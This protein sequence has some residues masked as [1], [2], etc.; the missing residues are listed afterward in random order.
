LGEENTDIGITTNNGL[1]ADPFNPK[2]SELSLIE[3][4]ILKQK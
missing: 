1:F 4:A 3:E 2:S